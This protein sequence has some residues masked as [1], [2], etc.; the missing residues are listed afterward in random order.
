MYL[1][2]LDLKKKLITSKLTFRRSLCRMVVCI[3]ATVKSCNR[4]FLTL[5]LFRIVAIGKKIYSTQ[6][7]LQRERKRFFM[8]TFYSILKILGIILESGLVLQ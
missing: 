7:S 5:I 3:V 4:F 8:K 6:N 2:T 1:L